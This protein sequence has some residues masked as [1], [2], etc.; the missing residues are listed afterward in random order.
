[1][2]YSIRST[3]VALLLL[4][5]TRKIIQINL[6]SINIYKLLTN[7]NIKNAT[8]IILM[9]AHLQEGFNFRTKLTIVR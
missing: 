8:P 5:T 1:M 9:Y 7:K 3:K 4:K 6:H 2:V